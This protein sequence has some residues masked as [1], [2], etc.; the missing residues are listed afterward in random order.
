MSV[1]LK[2]DAAAIWLEKL[3]ARGLA[4]GCWGWRGAPGHSHGALTFCHLSCGYLPST[5]GTLALAA[6]GK[7][8]ATG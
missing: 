7:A 1:L 6:A 3:Y 4:A 5:S 2:G 8:P